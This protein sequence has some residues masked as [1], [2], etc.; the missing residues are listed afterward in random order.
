M[1]CDFQVQLLLHHP[2]RRVLYFAPCTMQTGRLR[3]VAPPL[4]RAVARGTW[5]AEFN[6]NY[7]EAGAVTSVQA[8][9]GAVD[10]VPGSAALLL[11]GE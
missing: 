4:L 1:S 6:T 9:C 5:T 7:D 10:A 2:K 11:G 3:P 8:V